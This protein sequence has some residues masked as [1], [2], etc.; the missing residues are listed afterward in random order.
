MQVTQHDVVRGLSEILVHA[1]QAEQQRACGTQLAQELS[2]SPFSL[3]PLVSEQW[4]SSPVLWSNGAPSQS[5]QL[6]ADYMKRM[7]I[8]RQRKCGLRFIMVRTDHPD[9]TVE[10][11]FYFEYA[12]APCTVIVGQCNNYS[13]PGLIG[14]ASLRAMFGTMSALSEQPI[15]ES[16]ISLAAEQQALDRVRQSFLAA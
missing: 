12:T 7:L 5:C 6:M 9:R 14:A 1:E 16:I 2:A 15:Q 11:D 13:A 4:S 10:H 3:P 8:Q